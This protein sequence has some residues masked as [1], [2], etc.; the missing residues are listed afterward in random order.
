[1]KCMSEE[2]TQRCVLLR[3]SMGVSEVKLTGDHEKC[4]GAG[5]GVGTPDRSGFKRE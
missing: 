2:K 4:L 1:M 3:P 5:V